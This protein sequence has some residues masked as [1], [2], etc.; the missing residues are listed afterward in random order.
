MACCRLLTFVLT[1]SRGSRWMLS[2]PV[3]ILKRLLHR[4]SSGSGSSSS[5]GSLSPITDKG[6]PV[7]STTQQQK[8]ARGS[9]GSDYSGSTS[10]SASHRIVRAL[11]TR[12][13]TKSNR[14]GSPQQAQDAVAV[15]TLKYKRP[16][17]SV[18]HCLFH[19]LVYIDQFVSS[20][21]SR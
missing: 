8:R 10:T 20:L 13:R 5:P 4:E 16:K 18:R 17:A 3:S 2:T 6:F 12:L 7:S 14:S 9:V 19:L 11:S 1:V 21:L 15:Q